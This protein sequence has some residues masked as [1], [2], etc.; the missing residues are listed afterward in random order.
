MRA[1]RTFFYVALGILALSVAFS[2][3]PRASKSQT[4]HL[5]FGAVEENGRLG[6]S[7][8]GLDANGQLWF[9]VANESYP[10]G[11]RAL[12]KPG[13]IVGAARSYILYE[14]GDIYAYGG[15][16]N[17]EPIGWTFLFNL[18]AQGPTQATETTWGRIKADRR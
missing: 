5:V 13:T 6:P 16:I 9:N 10:D 7:F 3:H 1:A 4:N 12:P 15:V 18:F 2:L 11:P 14:D 8:T 17:G